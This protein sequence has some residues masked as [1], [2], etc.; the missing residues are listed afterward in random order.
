MNRKIKNKIAI[1]TSSLQ[2][3]LFKLFTEFEFPITSA[4]VKRQFIL[5]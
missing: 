3:D 5:T 2:Q 1:N 4:L